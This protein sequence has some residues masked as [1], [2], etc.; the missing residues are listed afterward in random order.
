MTTL[1]SVDPGWAWKP[2]VPDAKRPWDLRRAAH[3]MRRAGFGG[4]W[5]TLRQAVEDGPQAAVDRLLRPQADVEAF[6]RT[7]DQLESDSI[8]VDATSTQTLRQWWLRRMLLSPHVLLEK[9]TLFWHSHF[10]VSGGRV[11]N[12]RLVGRHIGLLRKHALGSFSEL[13]G[14]ICR[15]PAM[16]AN[17]GVSRNPR[18]RPNDYLAR[19]VLEQYALGPGKCSEGD[20]REAARAFTGCSLLRGEYRFRDSEH[21]DGPKRLLG[22]Q[23]AWREADVVRIALAQPEAPRYLV[24]KL[25]AWLISEAAPAPEAL[26]EPLARTFGND[27]QVGPLVETMLRSNLFF[28]ADAYR[29]RIKSPVEFAVGIARGLGDLVPTGPAGLAGGPAGPGTVPAADGARMGGGHALAEP[30]HDGRTQQRGRGDAGRV[31]R[32]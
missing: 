28:S 32:L 12:E 3:L 25:F 26:I 4:D 16:L 20:V 17:A 5:P 7:Y 18:S 14:A 15:D 9:M 13:L 11:G 30:V 1:D 19:V 29:Q 8:D 24:R 31:G 10:G 23:G 21:D 6:N 22:E 27:Y 2:Y